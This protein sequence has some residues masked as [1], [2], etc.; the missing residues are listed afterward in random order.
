MTSQI[1]LIAAVAKNG[2]IGKDNDLPWRIPEDWKYF[3]KMTTG[4]TILMGRK[5]FE[6]LGQPL[7]NRK[8]LVITRQSDYHV[9]EGV[10]V[11]TSIE[12]A[13]IAHPLEDIMVIGGGEIYKQTIEQADILYITHVNRDVSG[14][15]FFPTIDRNVWQETAQENHEGFSFVTYKRIYS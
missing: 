15:T 6:S 12:D 7:P 11:Y 4:K 5:T 10:E 9:P 3:K 2:V 14:D 1:S 8:H 13:L